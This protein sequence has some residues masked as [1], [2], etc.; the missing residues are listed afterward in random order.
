MFSSS[1][2][3]QLSLAQKHTKTRL[4]RFVWV[5]IVE[6]EVTMR[7]KSVPEFCVTVGMKI[8]SRRKSGHTASEDA[9]VVGVDERSQRVTIVSPTSQRTM[10]MRHLRLAWKPKIDQLN[11]GVLVDARILALENKM[12][13]LYAWREKMA[14]THR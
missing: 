11:Q 6:A 13:E 7:K 10:S 14:S 5:H 2:N 12:A 1:D 3:Y 9:E 8:T 4:D